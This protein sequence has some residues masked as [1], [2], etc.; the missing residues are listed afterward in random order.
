MMC[1]VFNYSN[2]MG[3]KIKLLL[4]TIFIGEYLN[5]LKLYILSFLF[6]LIN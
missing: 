1:N 4:L 6:K 5:K 3:H 2:D